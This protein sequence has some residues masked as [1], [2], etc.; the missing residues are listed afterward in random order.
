MFPPLLPEWRVGLWSVCPEQIEPFD[1]AGS[2]CS[3]G[4]QAVEEHVPYSHFLSVC[5]GSSLW[6]ISSSVCTPAAW[7]RQSWLPPLWGH[8]RTLPAKHLPHLIAL[9]S[10]HLGLWWVNT[11][12]LKRKLAW[13]SHSR[14]VSSMNEW[15]LVNHNLR[16]GILGRHRR[17]LAKENGLC[18]SP[19]SS[20]FQGLV[21]S[22]L[23]L[24]CHTVCTCGRCCWIPTQ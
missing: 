7:P 1:Q 11:K 22:M 20:P 9:I 4:V 14:N 8:P 16:S 17:A 13:S 3:R 2:S 24:K 5:S 21:I 12:L 6:R 18:S 23:V 15:R 10:S 19:N